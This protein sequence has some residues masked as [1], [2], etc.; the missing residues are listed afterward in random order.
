MAKFDD[1]ITEDPAMTCIVGRYR[2]NL[3]EEDSASFDRALA[4]RLSAEAILGVIREDGIIMSISA[5]RT[6]RRC[7]C[8]CVSA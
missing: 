2:Q 7:S 1:L 4:S 8:N 6:H 5:L 3:S